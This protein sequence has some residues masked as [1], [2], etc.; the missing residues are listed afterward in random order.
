[1]V[2]I[3]HLLESTRKTHFIRSLS[4]ELQTETTRV[5]QMNLRVQLRV[6]QKVH[7]QVQVKEL[8][9]IKHLLPQAKVELNQKVQHWQVQVRLNQNNLN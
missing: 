9:Q 5:L 3:H 4:L 6:L 7:Q 8:I 1:M 2:Q